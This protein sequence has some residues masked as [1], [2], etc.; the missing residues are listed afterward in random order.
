MVRSMNTGIFGCLD[1]GVWIRGGSPLISFLSVATGFV[2]GGGAWKIT[3]AHF[4]LVEE[5]RMKML[6]SNT[7]GKSPA[8]I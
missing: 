1:L 3:V 7:Y 2:F 5:I 6:D 8:Q 4:F